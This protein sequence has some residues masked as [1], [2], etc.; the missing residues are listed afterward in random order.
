MKLQKL[1]T[2]STILTLSVVL[3]GC[4][5]LPFIKTYDTTP[6]TPIPTPW[7]RIQINFRP[8]SQTAT[9]KPGQQSSSFIPLFINY[10]N[11]TNTPQ[12]GVKITVSSKMFFAYGSSMATLNKTHTSAPETIVYDIADVQPGE[13]KAAVVVVYA[14]HVG[15]DKLSIKIA[16]DQG[17][18]TSPVSVDLSVEEGKK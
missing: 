14:Q 18:V 11:M 6:S 9:L 1:F 2:I 12:T 3:S 5:K 16:T 17:V 4:S 15:T 10:T 7:E 13:T 8:G